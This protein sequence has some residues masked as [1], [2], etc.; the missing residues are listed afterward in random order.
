MA[1]V[2]KKGTMNVVEAAEVRI[3]NIFANGVPV[4]MGFSAG[5]DSLS[6]AQL[7]LNLIK[8]GEIDPKLLTI[9]FIDEE[10][11][12]PCIERT[13]KEWRKKFL[14]AGANFEWYCIEILH[15]NALNNLSDDETFLCWDR[16]EKENWVRPMPKFAKTS[17]PLLKAREESYQSFLDRIESNGI[18]IMGVRVAESVQRLSSLSKRKSNRKL[19]PIYDW[20]DKDVWKYLLEENVKIPEVYMY[21]WQ[22]GAARNQLRV[23][24]F[25]SVD[26][27]RSL[28]K[29]N[30]YYPDLMERVTRREPNAY[31][32]AM[33]WDSEMFGRTTANRK[34]SEGSDEKVDY[35]KKVWDLLSDIDKNF[36]TEGLRKNAKN[37]RKLVI[38][39]GTVINQRRYKAIYNSLISGDPKMRNYRAILT[40]IHTDGRED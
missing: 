23:S 29:M 11:I 20:T 18:T 2:R 24:Q 25:F 31:L 8:R 1:V 3:K 34:R 17:H 15:F 30:E 16:Y 35:K 12:Y 19:H 4:Y 14:M 27:V 26:T 38:H 13:A 10:A 21:L 37:L 22:S 5:K 6:L 9:H 33:Y 28:V 32:A 7:V 36:R 39:D 40:S